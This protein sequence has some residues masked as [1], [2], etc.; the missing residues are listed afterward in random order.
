MKMADIWR[1]DLFILE[2]LLNLENK[3]AVRI[4]CF[5]ILTQ[6]SLCLLSA[7]GFSGPLMSFDVK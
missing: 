6:I 3:D 1:G 2:Q 4:W 5:S 7:H